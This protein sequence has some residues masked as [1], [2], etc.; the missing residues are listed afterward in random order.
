ME[1]P[2]FGG[3]LDGFWLVG[4]FIGWFGFVVVVGLFSL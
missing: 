2:A 4:W 3:L 1:Q